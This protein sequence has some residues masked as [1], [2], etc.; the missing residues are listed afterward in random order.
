[1]S[2]IDLSP[3][4]SANGF[5]AAPIC[6]KLKSRQGSIDIGKLRRPRSRPGIAMITARLFADLIGVRDL[7]R[8][9]KGCR[10]AE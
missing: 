8:I 6:R 10:G 5:A 9:G 3:A 7:R 2:N 1:M 4:N